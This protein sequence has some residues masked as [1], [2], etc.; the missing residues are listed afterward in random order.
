VSPGL[1]TNAVWWSIVTGAPP[2]STG[3]F[4]I[5]QNPAPERLPPNLVYRAKTLGLHTCAHFSDQLTM[6]VGALLPFDEDHSGPRGWLQVTTAALKDAGWLLPVILPHLPRLPGAF[7]PQNQAHTYAFSLRR[8]LSEI[9]TCGGT[10]RGSLTLAHVDYLHQARY[11][12]FSELTAPERARVWS[13]PVA[14]LVD[15]SID[16]QY[17]MT[18]GEPLRVY[19][20]KLSALQA[21]LRTAIASTGVLEPGLHSRL[22][23]LSDHGPRI[24]LT[25]K[26]FG[27]ERYH[28]VILATFGI[29]PRDP[30]E[31]ISLLDVGTLLGLGSPGA[32]AADPAVEYVEALPSDSREMAQGSRPLLDGRISVP[33][34]VLERMGARLLRFR[35]FG[36]Q[37][38]Y[39]VDIATPASEPDVAAPTVLAPPKA[40]P[41]QHSARS[42][43]TVKAKLVG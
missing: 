27:D 38:G 41:E 5:F 7:T 13:A 30:D 19:A 3:V 16:W 20:W 40:A 24:G 33:R 2:H 12:G 43:A 11:P 31:A 15:R 25:T 37:Q 6:Q 1:I 9:L 17:P 22:V 8:E 10:P 36:G 39:S 18:E 34:A 26:N 21:T 32:L 4:F 29:E 23:F 14:A 28:G 35:P 42:P